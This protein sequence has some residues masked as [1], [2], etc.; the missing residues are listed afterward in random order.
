MPIELLFHLQT[1]NFY[2]P[3][4]VKHGDI[5]TCSYP[6]CRAFGV[7]FC[8]CVYCNIPVA[9]RCFRKRHHHSEEEEGAAESATIAN[10]STHHSTTCDDNDPSSP[11]LQN[12]S[13][14]HSHNTS[15]AYTKVPS[16]CSEEPPADTSDRTMRSNN[17]SA[18]AASTHDVDRP[19]SK[20]REFSSSCDHVIYQHVARMPKRRSD[21]NFDGA[22]SSALVM[23]RD[24]VSK[25]ANECL[26]NSD[27]RFRWDALL[28]QRPTA[29]NSSSGKVDLDAWLLSVVQVSDFQK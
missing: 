22:A 27:R 18:L 3:R 7:K 6:A 2:I 28:S 26:L 16:P 17:V 29:V 8:F 5:L 13:C 21:S 4:D 10:H 1:A 25:C 12:S 14:S 9:K 15:Q 20:K 11:L 24:H 23:R 19:G